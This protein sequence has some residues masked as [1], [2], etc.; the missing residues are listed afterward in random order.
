MQWLYKV[1]TEKKRLQPPLSME[2][3]LGKYIR[4]LFCV[5]KAYLYLSG[6]TITYYLLL[7]FVRN[8]IRLHGGFSFCGSST[9]FT[10]CNRQVFSLEQSMVQGV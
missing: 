1:H 5:S 9:R 6:F 10:V 3:S 4:A 2:W 8:L 7:N